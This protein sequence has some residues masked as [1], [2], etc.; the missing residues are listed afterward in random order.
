MMENWKL[1]DNFADVL[2]RQARRLEAMRRT[3]LDLFASHGF[4]L[5]QPPL[6]EFVDSL[7]T[8]NGRDLGNLTFKFMDQANGRT[9]GLR[10]D[11]TPQIARIDAH[12]LNRRGVARLCYALN[13]LH[14]RARHPLASREPIVA[15]AE[16]FGASGAEADAEM[17]KLAVKALRRLGCKHI[18]IDI[19]HAGVLHAILDPLGLPGDASHAVVRALKLKDGVALAAAAAGLPEAARKAVASL[20]RHY[21][22]AEA[23]AALRA[24]LGG[25]P[26]IA[27]AL[28]EAEALASV[29]GA[30]GVSFDFAD[31]SGYQYLTGFSFS[32]YLPNHA[33]AVLRGGR[34]DGVGLAFG[35]SRPACG[36]TAYLRSILDALEAEDARPRACVARCADGPDLEPYLE[37]LRAEGRV[38]IR[39]LAGERLEDVSEQFEITHEVVRT[40]SGLALAEAV[41]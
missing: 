14:L 30:D 3:C 5:V 17:M 22:G 12:I 4:E 34:Y 1:P 25:D 33:Q 24:E 32:V 28:A 8:G 15:G 26:V 2:P 35:R 36:F 38:V 21:G 16:L 31:V 37:A 40:G 19:G 27:A 18:H 6:V 11:A 10:A 13:C 9:L 29:C 23:L 39:L 20:A 7:L 41:S